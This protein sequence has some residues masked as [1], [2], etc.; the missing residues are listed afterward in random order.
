MEAS[1]ISMELNEPMH[2]FKFPDHADFIHLFRVKQKYINNIIIK[3]IKQG[4]S[5]STIISKTYIQ[6]RLNYIHIYMLILLSSTLQ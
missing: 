1:H 2:K 6:R 3:N 4:L 5:N